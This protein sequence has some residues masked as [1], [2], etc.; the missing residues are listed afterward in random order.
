[1]GPGRITAPLRIVAD[2]D[3]SN[4]TKPSQARGE[5][6][7]LDP[8]NTGANDGWATGPLDTVGDSVSEPGVAD[9]LELAG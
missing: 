3:G 6:L 4:S 1:V 5:L 9:P 7:G 8:Q 2:P